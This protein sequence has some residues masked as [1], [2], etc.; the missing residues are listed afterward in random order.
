[1]G[2]HPTKDQIDSIYPQTANIKL[3]TVDDIPLS[4]CTESLGKKT[5]TSSLVH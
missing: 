4:G 2:T 3:Q 1:M 5:G